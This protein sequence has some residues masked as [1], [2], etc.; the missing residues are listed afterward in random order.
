MTLNQKNINIKKTKMIAMT[1]VTALAFASCKK[2]E[3]TGSQIPNAV[4][5]TENKYGISV[6]NNT[7]KF[8]T[9]EKYNELLR[10]PMDEKYKFYKFAENLPGFTSRAEYERMSP[11]QRPAATCDCAIDD[12]YVNS[13]VNS[14]FIVIIQDFAVKLNGCD[15]TVIVSDKLAPNA[16]DRDAALVNCDF[17]DATFYRYTFQ[18]VVEEELPI[19]RAILNNET[20]QARCNDVAISDRTVRATSGTD[21]YGNKFPTFEIKYNNNG[22]GGS[23]KVAMS[24]F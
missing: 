15:N 2:E 18:D 17:S 7:L 13:V 22:V 10:M 11:S 8:A 12:E 5:Q 14:N 24:L 21:P 4:P 1:L 16:A 20:P 6:E 9:F 3:K 19:L 23:I